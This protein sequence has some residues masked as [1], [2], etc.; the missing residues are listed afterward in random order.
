MHSVRRNVSN[1]CQGHQ[2]LKLFRRNN[3]NHL[4]FLEANELSN[5]CLNEAFKMTENLKFIRMS[6][7]NKA[8]FRQETL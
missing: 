3:N 4:V 2:S 6:S 7:S 1:R 5:D 8:C